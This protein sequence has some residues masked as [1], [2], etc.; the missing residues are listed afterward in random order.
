VSALG[1]AGFAVDEL[2]EVQ[3][4]S[5]AVPLYLDVRLRLCN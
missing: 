3:G 1:A 5:S 2:R 4:R